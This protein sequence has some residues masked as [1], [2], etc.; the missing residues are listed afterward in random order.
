MTALDG[1]NILFLS[2]SFFSYE[3][4]IAERLRQWGANVDFFDERPSNT[5]LSKGIIRIYPEIYRFVIDSYYRR[6]LKL[7]AG[8]PY[9]FLLLIKGEAV[10]DFFLEEIRRRNSAIRMIYY[11]FDP[12]DEY[13]KTRSLLKFF[14][15][16]FTFD[17][18]DAEKYKISFRPLFFLDEYRANC[19]TSVDKNQVWDICFIGSAH[20]DRYTV[21]EEIRKN[22]DRLG[23]RSF[24]FYYAPGKIAF[25]LRRIFDP[26]MK[27]FDLKKVSFNKLRHRD[28]ID[29]Y[30]KSVAV[31]DINKPFQD[32]L[33]MR[34]FETLAMGRKLMTTNPDIR[35]YPFY[36]PKNILVVSRDH[37]ELQPDFFTSDFQEIPENILEKMTLDSWIECLFIRNQDEYWNSSSRIS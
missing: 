2:V 36:N 14:D 27:K 6:I 35:N 13:P 34:T 4:A 5:V 37:I 19:H 7:T 18:A 32:G 30:R 15:I 22:A 29:R 24:Y 12:I 3:K 17:R 25:Y 31:L 16:C 10:P 26:N 9:D 23:L 1:K 28:I 8:R 20:T 21:G 11:T 33:T